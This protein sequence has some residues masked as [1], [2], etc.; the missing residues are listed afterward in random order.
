M[1]HGLEMG[2]IVNER[3]YRVASIKEIKTKTSS[4][5]GFQMIVNR[6]KTW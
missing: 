1:S 3:E 4:V 2:S 5:I 6:P